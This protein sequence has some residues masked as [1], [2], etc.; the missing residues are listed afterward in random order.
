MRFGLRLFLGYF[1]IV[2]VAGWFVLAIFTQEVKPGV[3]R[4]T[5]G[6]LV[7]SANVLA[8][9][10][11]ADMA[12]GDIANGRLARAFRDKARP[13]I[14]AN[15]SGI[16]KNAMEFRVYV[17][18]ARG[19]VIFDSSGR[20]LGRDYS[21][22]ND[23][24]RTLRGEY[25]ARSTRSDPKDENSSVMH[26]A[27]PVR[28]DGRIVGSL[29]V[30]KPN[31]TMEPVIRRSER[32]IMLAGGALLGAA[33]LIGAVMVWWI[34]RSIR[35]LVS[36]AEAVAAG[37]PA[38][39]P[40][41]GSPEL[42]SLGQAV[43]AMRRKLEGK[44]YVEG[45]VHTLSH[46][47]KSPLAAIR[48]AGEL[49]REDPPPE[50]RRRFVDNILAQSL[51]MQQ[52]IER[53]LWQ[54]R[55]ESRLR[56]DAQPLD[57]PALIE[58]TA[59][60]K[61]LAAARRA[62]RIERRL[63]PASLNGDRLLLTQALSNLLDN[64]LEFSPP[65]GVIELHGGLEEGGYLLRVRDHGPGVPD[66]ALERVFERFYS[67]PRPDSGKSTGLGLSLVR[68]VAQ[69]HGGRAELLNHADGGAEARLWL[70]LG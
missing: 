23:V 10:A 34:N 37:Q 53:L 31:V 4:A 1:L 55:V 52:L 3:R 66:Y 54:A 61:A 36:Y 45:Y 39:V 17:T 49:L 15:I 33:L 16:V 14:A 30:S 18:D 8:G 38:N 65:G 57:W 5:E 60:G 44:A 46:E 41:L 20:D 58:E 70:P 62:A 59:D 47:L 64:A 13:P 27:A 48:G 50:T 56:P 29:T 11:A 69:L 68:E 22:W 26:V 6:T 28:L 67:L 7:D 2:A 25:G 51:R 63:A 12:D 19:M 40:R 9:I 42:D 35:R 24:Y 32:K 43:E 21:R